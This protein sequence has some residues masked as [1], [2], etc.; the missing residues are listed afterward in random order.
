MTCTLSIKLNSS[1]KSVKLP[2]VHTLLNTFYVS[3]TAIFIFP[4]CAEMEE[5]EIYMFLK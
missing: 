2:N 1:S 5:V 4:V 3:V